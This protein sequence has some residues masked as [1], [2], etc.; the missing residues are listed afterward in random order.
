M[1]IH[2]VSHIVE[3]VRETGPLWANSAF[4]FENENGILKKHIIGTNK[5]AMQV[6]L[7]F[8]FFFFFFSKKTNL[9]LFLLV[10]I[11]DN[12]HQIAQQIKIISKSKNFKSPPKARTQA[13]PNNYK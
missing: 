2:N 10:N 1:N 4:I 7:F 9:M 6:I 8:S 5:I 12:N 3:S 11:Y 13:N